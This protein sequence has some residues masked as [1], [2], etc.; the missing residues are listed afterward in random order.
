MDEVGSSVDEVGSG[1]EDGGGVEDGGNGG[2][3]V[4]VSVLV[5]VLGE[6]FEVDGA[7][8]AGGGDKVAGEGGDRSGDLSC[9]HGGGEKCGEDDLKRKG[10]T[11][12]HQ[13][14]LNIEYH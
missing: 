14:G 9:G 10:K 11:N 3:G 4:D 8:P 5:Q 1:T 2:N 6:S 12:K 7:E 13:N